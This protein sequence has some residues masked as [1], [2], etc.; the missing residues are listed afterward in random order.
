MSAGGI[1]RPVQI[2]EFKTAISDMS[3]EELAHLKQEIE[4]SI[5]HLNR[6]NARLNKYVAKLEGKAKAE[7]ED[8][9]DEELQNIEEGDLQLYH[10]SLRENEIL[11]KNYNERLEA[12]HQENVYRTS[13]G[14]KPS[15]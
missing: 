5:L 9:D 8:D 7:E 3:T 4:N 15:S 14:N 6:S 13:G 12:L 1:R 11:L 2:E 10:D